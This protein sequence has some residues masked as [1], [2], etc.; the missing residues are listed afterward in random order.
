MNHPVV[1]PTSLR[2]WSMPRVRTALLAVALP[3]L[4]ATAWAQPGPDPVLLVVDAPVAGATVRVP[5]LL[6]GWAL[7]QT[8]LTDSGI[9]VI[10]LWAYP[11]PGGAS[12]FLGT[13]SLGGSRPD[14]AAAYGAQYRLSG[15]SASI[16]ADLP[17]GDYNIAVFPHRTSTQHFVA[18]TI[19]PITVRGV[20]LSDLACTTGQVPS[21]DGT[22]W[23]C[24][25]PTGATGPA[26]PAGATGATGATGPAGPAGVTGAAGPA[27]ATGA[28]GA[29]GANGAT[30]ATGAAGA[31]GPAGPAGPAGA[32]GVTGAAGTNGATGATGAAGPAG[33]TGATGPQGPAMVAEFAYIYSTS[34]QI[35]PLE[36][37]VNFEANGAATSGISHQLG[38]S[39]IVIALAG[40]YDIAFSVSAVEPNQFA[41]FLNGAPVPGSLY[42]SGAGTQQ[43]TGHV[44]LVLGAGDIVTLRNHTSSTA[45]TLQTLAGGTQTNVNASILIRKLTDQNP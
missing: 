20:T 15:F 18:A 34:A 23:G 6:S 27:G 14:V 33:E 43:T 39:S 9:D 2:M 16:T 1:S 21:W 12:V 5:F 40:I 41:L 22:A 45:V 24:I 7:D 35:V 26:G 30:G 36:T 25:D 10:H 17:P 13:A 37:D 19:V 29:A 44:I 31:T 3:F 8:A 4:A 38:T 11:V 32:N 42:G 28:T